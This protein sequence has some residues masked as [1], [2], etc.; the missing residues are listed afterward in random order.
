MIRPSRIL[1]LLVPV[2]L[3][4]VPAAATT[5]TFE[6]D[7]LTQ[8]DLP[9]GVVVVGI[10][11]ARARRE[12]RDRHARCRDARRHPPRATRSTSRSAS[13]CRSPDNPGR[14]PD[15]PS[16]GAS[17][18]ARADAFVTLRNDTDAALEVP[19]VQTGGYGIEAGVE[20]RFPDE[21]RF[22]P[23]IDFA[24][25]TGGVFVPTVDGESRT[26]FDEGFEGGTGG[27]EITGVSLGDLSPLTETLLLEAGAEQTF[28]VA[29]AIA[30]GGVTNA[31]AP[32]PLPAAAWLLLAGAERAEGAPKGPN[33]IRR[34][35]VPRIAAGI[36]EPRSEAVPSPIGTLRGPALWLP[37]RN[38]PHTDAPRCPVRKVARRGR[39]TG[40]TVP[41]GAHRVV[42]GIAA[43]PDAPGSRPRAQVGRQSDAI[44]G[45]RRALATVPVAGR[46]QN[47]MQSAPGGRGAAPSGRVG[48]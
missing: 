1:P 14:G 7:V 19:I 4:A 48:A 8:L 22:A 11:R 17:I 35:I 33:L 37:D 3:A 18:D 36:R 16:L 41:D 32:I 45:T 28:N 24:G 21:P 6:A 42:T 20:D 25:I 29:A 46:A 23:F 13:S 40:V 26:A 10:E 43:R 2:A 12:R 38:R 30:N 9:E 5:I 44:P 15:A 34:S 47:I 27:F 39:G 31:P